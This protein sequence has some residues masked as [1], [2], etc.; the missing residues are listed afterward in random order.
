MEI[1][2]SLLIFSVLLTYISGSLRSFEQGS[3]S[4]LAP[5]PHER[6]RSPW[7]P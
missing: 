5:W 7:R 6:T 2:S 1:G 4:F 3:E